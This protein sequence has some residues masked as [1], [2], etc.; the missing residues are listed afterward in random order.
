MFRVGLS[1]AV[2]VIVADQ[3]SK[4]WVAA[5]IAL[6][7]GVFVTDFFNLVHTLNTGIS[8]S[9]FQGGETSRWIFT[10]LALAVVAAL[11]VWLRRA[12]SRWQAV[13]LGGIIGGALGNA[14]DRVRI[15]GVVDFL[16]VH[17][18]GYHWPAFNLADSAIV[19]GAAM[20]LLESLLF[21]RQNA[22]GENHRS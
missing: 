13:A 22:Q 20:I 15:G 11:L 1:V 9:M 19:V 21:G 5:E 10:G 7:R 3:L 17:A 18:A 12:N 2:G 8:F 14:I 6:G 16:D 4:A